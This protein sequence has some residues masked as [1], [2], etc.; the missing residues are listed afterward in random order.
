MAVVGS[1]EIIVRAITTKV[2]DDIRKAFEDVRPLIAAEGDKAGKA[3]SDSFSK[4]LK[5]H[6]GPE[7]QGAVDEATKGVRGELDRGL[8]GAADSASRKAGNTIRRNLGGA[9]GGAGR[10]AAAQFASVFGK[11]LTNAIQRISTLASMFDILAPAI[12]N[13][14]GA[15]SSLV[16]G[17]FSVIAAAGQAAGALAVLPGLLGALLQGAGALKLAFGGVG[18]AITAG[19]KAQDAATPAAQAAAAAAKSTSAAAKSN[20]DAVK[21]A[22]ELQKAQDRLTQAQKDAKAAQDALKKAQ[23]R[24]NDG[25]EEQQAAQNALNA[26]KQAAQQT[27][28]DP[29][30]SAQQGADAQKS[31]DDARNALKAITKER[32]DAAKKARKLAADN[33]AAQA[34]LAAAQKAR[35]KAAQVPKNAA[36]TGGIQTPAVKAANAY[37]MALANLTPEAKAF[38]A[39]VLK[40]RAAFKEVGDAVARELFPP[41]TQALE[42][43]GDSRFFDILK[44]NLSQTGGI[45]GQAGLNIAKAFTTNPNMD[46]FQTWLKQNNDILDTLNTKTKDG[47]TPLTALVNIITKLA[48]AI[49]PVTKRFAEWVATLIT[50]FDNTHKV[51]DLTKFFNKAGNEA[52][53]LGRLAGNIVGIIKALGKAAIPAGNGLIGSF[54]KATGKLEKFLN[55]PKQQKVL[56]QFFKDTANNFRDIGDLVDEIGK[57]FLGLGDNKGI[58]TFSKSLI[59]AVDAIGEIADK[60]TTG[61]VGKELGQ[62]ASGV[63]D[64]LN[65]LTQSGQTKV[66]FKTLQDIVGVINAMVVAFNKLGPVATIVLGALGAYRALNFALKILGFSKSFDALR[67]SLV[68]LAKVGIKKIAGSLNG[69]LPEKLQFKKKPTVDTGLDTADAEAQGKTIGESLADGIAKGIK[70]HESVVTTALA[71]LFLHLDDEFKDVRIFGEEMGQ[72]IVQGLAAGIQANASLAVTAIDELGIEVVNALK[73]KLGIKSPSVVME[74][75]GVNTGE[76]FVL[77]LRAETGAAFTAGEQL[78]ASATAG[79]KSGSAGAAAAGAA[80]AATA[81]P[82]G[83]ISPIAGAGKATSKEVAT[84]E[85]SGGKAAKLFGKI[86]KAAGGAASL[87]LP[88][89]FSLEAAGAALGAIIL[90][91]LAVVGAIA[92]FVGIVVLLYKKSPQFKLFV[93]NIVGKLKDLVHWFKDVVLPIVKDFAEFLGKKFVALIVPPLNSFFGFVNRELPKIGS[94]FGS[95]FQAIGNFY[96]TYLA[97]V[98]SVIGTVIVFLWNKVVKPY[99]KLIVLYFQTEFKVIKAIWNNILKPV[100][101]AIMDIAKLVFE[102]IGVY[103]KIWVKIFQGAFS[104]IKA[105]WNNVLHPVFDA[106]KSVAQTVFGAVGNY[107][108]KMKDIFNNVSDVVGRVGGAIGNAFDKIKNAAKAPIKFVID[109]VWNNGIVALA[110]HIPGVNASGWKINTSGWAKGG[111]TG[112]G[113]KYQPAGIVHRDEFVIRKEARKALESAFPGMLSFMNKHGKLPTGHAGGGQARAAQYT[114]AIK[115]TLRIGLPGY[116]IGDFVKNVGKGAFHVAGKAIKWSGNFVKHGYKWTKDKVEAAYDAVKGVVSFLKSI[117]RKI[118]SNM[119]S[120][121]GHFFQGVPKAAVVAVVKKINDWVPDITPGIPLDLPFNGAQ[122]RATGGRVRKGMPYVVGENEPEL[123]VPDVSGTVV[124]SLKNLSNKSTVQ[125]ILDQIERLGG[126]VQLVQNQS[127]Q[128]NDTG[129]RNL[130]V[131]IH[132][133]ERER[134]SQSVSKAVRSKAISH[135]WGI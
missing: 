25:L 33:D 68:N 5:G 110:D 56:K 26:A 76:G 101:K 87:F 88:F 53:K 52:E 1:A 112:P 54:T 71:N 103:I 6:L 120:E 61:E 117:P 28:S 27:L 8:D 39:E 63:A 93:D 124:R 50:G 105:I 35:D 62:L 81:V 4:S 9:G 95:A 133:P 73:L 69:L 36:N 48:I 58:G 102:A 113:G 55:T 74:K 85:K 14:V 64:L 65:N 121:W 97:P 40:M 12:F 116:G 106:I 83:G 92:A 49:Q 129:A 84:L 77:G 98:F 21:R 46:R 130:T 109:T 125:D 96:S 91:V 78:A 114:G 75:L 51:N 41:L 94:A 45:I 13:A 17:L 82:G 34:K 100:F 3:Y 89:S 32:E 104:V 131:N 67:K 118:E 2:K 43:I 10:N 122:F 18:A 119:S 127:A 24:A 60:L 31:V 23:D 99:L 80:T 42:L 37:Q 128:T 123:F 7:L 29:N 90:P 111:Y 115:P 44:T 132:N 72:N 134:S 57:V 15:V 30:A 11:D 66:F 22:K 19:A 86:G 20:A 108:N 16:S 70:G 135:G 126:N 107:I 38:V 79:A 59:P 47:E